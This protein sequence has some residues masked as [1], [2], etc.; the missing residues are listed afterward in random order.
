MKALTF[1]DIIIPPQ[2]STVD[3]RRD[4]D[5]SSDLGGIGKLSIPI[6]SANM[7]TVT[8]IEMAI[9]IS[10]LG[11]LGILHRFMSI[12][13]NIKQ[14]RG[15]SEHCG[16]NKAV[17]SVG[18]KEEEV[19]RFLALFEVGA[20]SFCLDVAHGHHRRVKQMIKYMKEKDDV[21][22][23]AG[24]IATAAA[25]EDL[26]NWG[27]DI[28]KVGIG[29][30]LMCLTRRNAGVGVP[31]IYAVQ[32][33]RKAVPDKPIISDG[34]IKNTGCI[35]KAIAAGADAVMTGA[36][37]AGCHESP[38]KIWADDDEDMINQ[39]LYKIYRGSSSAEVKGKQEFVEGKANMISYKGPL[40]MTMSKID[41][42]LRI[43]LGYVGAKDLTEYRSK[44]EFIELTAG[45][46][47]E[48]ES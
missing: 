46:R 28:I 37:F 24:N 14:W 45:G 19:E 41:Y 7:D 12:D 15:V 32:Q 43:A 5:L 16:V 33:A 35:N 13:E 30:G 31:Q 4:V 25:A 36:L 11:G 44:S 17:V 38:G 10:K 48:S 26:S 27:A 47:I 39:R 34:G 9:E 1:D 6:I 23:I 29:P 18:T 3:S 42:G 40:S 22:V 21:C 20:R 8:E 2:Y